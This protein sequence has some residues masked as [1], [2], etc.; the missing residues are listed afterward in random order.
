MSED[1]WVKAPVLMLILPG[2]AKRTPPKLPTLSR[3]KPARMFSF[4]GSGF[5]MIGLFS[6]VQEEAESFCF[7]A[8]PLI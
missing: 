6:A 3:K 8:Q 2:G 5:D 1:P 7:I 4:Y